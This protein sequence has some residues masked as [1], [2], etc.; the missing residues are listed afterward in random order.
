MS[1]KQ[2]STKISNVLNEVL[3]NSLKEGDVA[4]VMTAWSQ[5][6]SELN[7]ILLNSSRVKPK[8]DPNAPK[9]PVSSYICFCNELRDSVRQKN[10]AMSIT[11]IAKELGKMWGLLSTKDKVKYEN[12]AKKDKERYETAMTSYTPPEGMETV[13][14]KGRSKKERTGPKKPVN[15]Y[16]YFGQV[17]REKLKNTVDPKDMMSEIAKKWKELSPDQKRPFEEQAK[18]DKERYENEKNGEN[19]V[20]STKRVKNLPPPVTNVVQLETKKSTKSKV[21]TDSPGFE[22]FSNER[23]SELE[24]DHPDWSMKKMDGELVKEWGLLSQKDRDA[25]ETE[26]QDDVEE[27][28][29]D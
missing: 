22:Y 18:K 28:L 15:A 2:L 14:T 27:E 20:E 26:A 9:K 1:T 8:K 7:R 6:Q 12:M 19:K 5:R 13:Q 11:Y 24:D 4:K 23:R 21:T 10:P 29:E 16:M 17:T 25:Y 3:S